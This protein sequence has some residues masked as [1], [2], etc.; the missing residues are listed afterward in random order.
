MQLTTSVKINSWRSIR[1]PAGSG[2]PTTR[3]RS[4]HRGLALLEIGTGPAYPH[5]GALRGRRPVGENELR[6]RAFQQGLGDE[7]AEP[8]PA[9]LDIDAVMQA[10]AA[11]H[12][13]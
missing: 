2:T 10:T 4:K 11:G 8:E 9:R 12:V 7:Q 1:V 6:A 13:R 3:R 5:A